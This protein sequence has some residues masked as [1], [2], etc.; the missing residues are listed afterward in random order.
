MTAAYAPSPAQLR[1]L[2]VAAGLV[3]LLT[4]PAALAAWSTRTDAAVV[5]PP[6]TVQPA[7][8]RRT[9]TVRVERLSGVAEPSASGQ[10]ACERSRKRLFV[11]GEG[12]I[13]RQVTLCR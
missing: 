7:P 13:V 8:E 11:E 4:A 2:A 12:W 6:A 3:S 5:S 1:R 9:R 10:P